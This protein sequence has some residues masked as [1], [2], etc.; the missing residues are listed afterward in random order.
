MKRD[1]RALADGEFDVLIL[2]GGAF[3][4]AAAWDATLRGLRVALLEQAD[5][6]GGASAE[7]FKMVHGGIRYLQHA[8]L[9]RL[10]ASCRERSALLRIAPHLVKPLPIIVPTFGRGRQGKALLGAGMYVYDALTLGRNAGIADTERRIA[11]TRFLSRS[12][13]LQLFPEQRHASLTGA[14]VFE[15]GQMYNPARLVLAF[16]TSAASKGAVAANYVQAQR[17]LWSGNTVRGVEAL[18]SL[19]GERFEVRARLTLNA[20]GPWAEYLLQDPDRFGHHKRGH[21]S[22]DAYFI[23]DRRPRSPYAL[24]V[25]GHSR[26]RDSLVNRSARHLFAVPWRDYTLIGVWHR[27]FTERPDTAQIEEAELEAWIDEMNQSQPALQLRREEVCYTCCGLVPFG[28][29]EATLNELSFGKESRFIDHR[30]VHGVNGLLTL[31]GIRFTTARGDAAHALDLLMQQW[32][33]SAPARARTDQ[34]R[35]AGGD[36]ENFAALL[37]SALAVRPPTLSARTIEALMHNHGTAYRE[38]LKL[39][40]D[41]QQQGTL[42]G[43]DTLIAEVAHAVHA[44]MALTLEDVVLRR[45]DLGSGSHPGRAA[46]E[47]AAD[48][49]QKLL[50]WSV[51][52]RDRELQATEAC[53]RRHHAACIDDRSVSSGAVASL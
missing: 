7:C 19:S 18:D 8:D 50:G 25:P 51:Q 4:A 9:R 30:R 15:D 21:F 22:R 47:Q 23:I 24:A 20:A 5:F 17:L 48:R 16:V 40:A 29:G 39:A 26:D 10:R 35:L 31:I 44:E 13:L 6:G 2:G 38:I 37:A 52:R 3:G 28:S 45:T 33:G 43:S 41:P 46:L 53:L 14:A 32:V 49:M 11:G 1:L 34:V 42:A 36:I 12:E 27:P